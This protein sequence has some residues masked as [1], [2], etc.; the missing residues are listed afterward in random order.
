MKFIRDMGVDK[1]DHLRHDGLDG[2]GGGKFVGYHG[3]L[4]FLYFNQ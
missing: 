1:T 4:S 3:Y 2:Q